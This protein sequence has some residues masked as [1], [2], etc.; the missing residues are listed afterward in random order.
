MADF[1]KGQRVR[2]SLSDSWREDGVVV[3][4]EERGISVHT[5]QGIFLVHEN[6]V[7]PWDPPEKRLD[8]ALSLL[9][10]WYS[11]WQGYTAGTP[12]NMHVRTADLLRRSGRE[13]QKG[14]RQ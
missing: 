3:G 1:A 14:P 6:E 9:A 13:I 4:V 11:R 5:A 8:E 10:L 12:E 2:V 7:E